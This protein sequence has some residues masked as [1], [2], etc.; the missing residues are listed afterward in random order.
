MAIKLLIV[1]TKR[2]VAALDP[3]DGKEVWRTKLPD[4]DGSVISLL[5]RGTDIYAGSYGRVFCLDRSTGKILWRNDLTGMGFQ[6]VLLTMD[7][8]GGGDGEDATDQA[9]IMAV[10]E[11]MAKRA[12]AASV[13]TT[14]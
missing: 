2:F 8:P 7:R 14:G 12:A 10:R 4:V 6:H 5:V 13:A 1:A 3:A 9:S 11:L